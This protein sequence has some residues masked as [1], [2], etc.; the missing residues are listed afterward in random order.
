MTLSGV[1]VLKKPPTR[2]VVVYWVTML[3]CNFSISSGVLNGDIEILRFFVD[4]LPCWIVEKQAE[5]L[6][7]KP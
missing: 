1:A 5:S 4:F 2:S 6:I 3:F 7:I